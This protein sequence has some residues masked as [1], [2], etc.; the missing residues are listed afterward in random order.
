[1]TRGIS[2]DRMSFLEARLSMRD[3]CATDGH[4]W[5]HLAKTLLAAFIA[6]GIAMRLELPQPRVAMTTT[7]VLMQPFS[8]MV[9][10][11]SVYRFAGTA[12]GM[13]AALVLGAVF[14]QQAELYALALTIW[15]AACTALAVRYRQFRWYGFVLAGYT[16]A[17]IGIPAVTDP[18]SLLIATLTR[19]AEVMLGIVCSSVVSALVFPRHASA[20]LAQSLDA[21]RTRFAAFA[22][23]VLR[24]RLSRIA[25]ERRFADFVDEIV[26]F[27]ATRGFAAYES[28]AMRQ[29]NGKLARLNSAFMDACARL[30]AL[31]QSMKRLRTNDATHCA[32]DALMP[33]FE[34][35]AHIF[36]RES[37]KVHLERYK[38]T[39]PKRL[40]DVQRSL[41]HA[42]HP[43]QLDFTTSAELLYRFITDTIRYVAIPDDRAAPRY[44]ARTNHFVIGATFVRTSIVITAAAWFW[45]DTAW[46]SGG[47]AV[48]GATLAC[49]LS[50]ALARPSKFIAQMA[51]GAAL[52]VV[53]GYV[54]L[55]HVYP[56]I[57]GIV[58][59]CAMLAPPLA[60][61]AFLA[62][63]PSSAGYGIGFC[64]FF[65]LLAAPDNRIVYDPGLLL[66]NGLA[67][68][69]A[70][71]GA[72]IACAVVVPPRAAWLVGKT[73][74]QLRAQVALACE[75]RLAGLGERFHSGTHDLMSQLRALHTRRSR[76]HRHAL[77]WML[78]TLEV[79]QAMID[80]RHEAR[81]LH[82][83]CFPDALRIAWSTSLACVLR[84][85]AVLFRAPDSETLRRA[86][87]SVVASI[88]IAQSMLEVAGADRGMR[89]E[90]QRVLACLHFVRTALVDPDAPFDAHR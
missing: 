88:V 9:L 40:R 65:C 48:I 56:A 46:P 85:I 36:E 10:A 16:A 23:D 50:S 86:I 27:E 29:H 33:F 49:A 58:L 80:L 70:M 74:E 67:V 63:R 35:L 22:A 34:E 78:V 30:H 38:T 14:V 26:G 60:A 11:K 7:F 75:G 54:Y 76:E 43:T 45:I 41:A 61:G 21:R 72:A 52:A 81:A 82:A 8:G 28:P 53:T 2:A 57:D 84:D 13:L 59:L 32:H 31:D 77:A 87:G 47:Y 64:V 42:D 44:E 19:G 89:H 37:L 62:M 5:L 1:M 17:L 18:N 71:L 24:G 4:V 90:M 3:W 79:G 20:T 66:N 15:V 55:C 12:L 73:L 51:A 69:V 39:L 83:Q 68:I 25:R 6:M